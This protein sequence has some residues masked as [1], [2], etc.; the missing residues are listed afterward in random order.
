VGRFIRKTS[1]DELPQLFNILR[2]EMSLVGPRP[3]PTYE[4]A[5]Y[6]D[7]HY[8]RLT[9]LPGITGLWQVK[10]RALTS[11]DEQIALD[12]EYIRHQSLW[13]DLKIILLTM[14]AVVSGKGAA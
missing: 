14:P 1:L 2:G 10:G 9:T 7:R 4:F 13:L 3:V 5:E 12:L 11:F 8:E 6:A